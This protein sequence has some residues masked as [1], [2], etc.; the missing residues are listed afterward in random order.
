MTAPMAMGAAARGLYYIAVMSLFGDLS[1]GL[2][3]RAKLPIIPPPRDMRLRWSALAMAIAAGLAWFVVAAWQ[4]AGSLDADA[5]TQSLSATLFGQLFAVRLLA[6]AALALVLH[7]HPRPAVLLALVALALPAATSHAA[8]A[9]PAGFTILGAGLDALHLATAGFWIGGLAALVQLHR[10]R[11]PNMLL[12]L[13]LFSE[14]AMIAVLLLVMTGLINGASILLGDPGRKS[15]A[16][17]AV[18]GAKLALV[19]LM[20]GLAVMNRFRLMP[21]GREQA[22]ARNAL[23]EL[24]AGLIVVLLAG[25]LGQ[26]PPVL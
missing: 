9:S 10:R 3:L 2:L 15:W 20:L 18:L 8:A 12:A 13:S 22:I 4:M 25:A 24:A 14:W 19:A 26:L 7:R 16:Y 21:Q 23:R 6:L 1:F 5:L 17:L 11:E